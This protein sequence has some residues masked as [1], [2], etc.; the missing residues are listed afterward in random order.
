MQ[1]DLTKG[2]VW[3]REALRDYEKSKAWRLARNLPAD[4]ETFTLAYHIGMWQERA[5]EQHRLEKSMQKERQ[6]LARGGKPRYYSIMNQ[7]R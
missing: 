6:R 4:D 1:I 2:V 7:G 5:I 3:F